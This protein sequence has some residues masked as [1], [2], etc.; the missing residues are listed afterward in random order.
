MR[1]IYVIML[2]PL[3]LIAAFWLIARLEGPAASTRPG[4]FQRNGIGIGLYLII[5]VGFWA[6][7]IIILPM[8]YMVDLSFRPKLPPAQIGGPKDVYTLEN[9]RFFLF[10][11]T[12]S[13]ANWNWIH[14]N[15]FFS[16]IA[17]SIVITL[18]NFVICYP[19]AYH[20]AQSAKLE[21]LRV[22]LLLLII[23]YWVNDIL[24]AFAL[25][26]LLSTGGVINQALAGLGLTSEPIDF[27]AANVGLYTGLSYAYLLLMIFP[28]YNAIES[29]DKNQIEAARDLGAPWWHIHTFIVMPHAKP[30]IAS[31]CTLVFMLC[32]GAVATPMVLGGPSTLWFTPIVY[33]RFYE[34]FNWPQGA[35]Y[36]FLLLMACVLFV[37]TVLR[38]TGLKLGEI[39][40]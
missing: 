37:L 18:L 22:L 25:R 34:L 38:L 12:T 24:R 36:A 7:F 2:L 17:A 29:L 1:S 16:T 26:V 39:A 33:D 13:T 4:F 31:G 21:S 32:T 5:A 35:A 8:V 28:L 3:V 27:L 14:I 23:P 10:G 15:A 30:G 40:R 9:Y 11:S 20:M 19:L 6:I